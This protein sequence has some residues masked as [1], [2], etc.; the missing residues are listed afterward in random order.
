[1]GAF[2]TGFLLIFLHPTVC[3]R[4]LW[5]GSTALRELHQVCSPQTTN[6]PYTIRK[7]MNNVWDHKW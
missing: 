5:D 7:Y 6:K 3:Q 2:V 1:M 4:C